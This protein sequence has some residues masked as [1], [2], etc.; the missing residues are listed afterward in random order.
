MNR[1]I[2]A[3]NRLFESVNL[4]VTALKRSFLGLASP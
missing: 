2:D 1:S 3:S 4:S